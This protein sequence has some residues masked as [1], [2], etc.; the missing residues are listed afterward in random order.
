MKSSIFIRRRPSGFTLVELL[1]VMGIIAVL[2]GVIIAAVSSA[3]RFA[4]R[5]RANATCVQIQTAMQNYYTEY[6]VYAA[7]AADSATATD[8]IY[9]GAA[10]VDTGRWQYLIWALCGNI[11]PLTGAPV[12]VGPNSVPNTRGIQYLAPTRSDIDATYGIP[13]NPFGNSATTPYYYMAVDNDYSGVVGDSG[14]ALAQLPNFTANSTNY[15]GTTLPKGTPGGIAVWCSC[16]QPLVGTTANPS[17]PYGWA[18][19]Y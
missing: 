15:M 7:S 8:L 3:M 19:T 6:G 5:T 1:V 16:D 9:S 2:C 13:A 14:T 11:N 17:R 4:K 18:H 10:G 12:P